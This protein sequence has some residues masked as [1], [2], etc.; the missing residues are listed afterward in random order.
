IFWRATLAG[1]TNGEPTYFEGERGLLFKIL[2]GQT[3]FI[4]FQFIWFVVFAVTISYLLN[5]T[6]FG[7][8]IMATGGSI[9]IARALGVNTY[10]TKMICFMISSTLAAFAGASFLVRSSYLDP[11]VATGME[12]E[13]VAAVVI[14]G[15]ILT[16]GIGSIVGTSI[17]AFLLKVVQV[18][19]ATYG[20]RVEYYNVLVGTLLMVAAII[21]NQLIKKMIRM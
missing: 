11:I 3:G 6:K 9:N 19:I 20:I 12:M 14:G 1:I 16:G 13:A 7:N 2:G 10:R 8:W 17:C 4:P 18:G 5:Q 21:N 15:T